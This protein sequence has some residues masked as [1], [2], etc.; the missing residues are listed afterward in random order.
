[1]HM[2]NM[3]VWIIVLLTSFFFVGVASAA[4]QQG[5]CPSQQIFDACS[6]QNGNGYMW[7]PISPKTYSCSVGADLS[8]YCSFGPVGE[9]VNSTTNNLGTTRY[10]SALACEQAVSNCYGAPVLQRP[11]APSY[12]SATAGNARADLSWGAATGAASYTLR[13]STSS[14]T[15]YV[16]VT[17][18]IDIAATSFVN[19]SLVNGTTYYYVV[20]AKNSGG[21]SPNSTEASVTP[22]VPPPVPAAPTNL[23]G[24]AGSG[25]ALLTWNTVQHATAYSIKRRTTPTGTAVTIGVGGVTAYTNTGLVDGTPYYFTVVAQNVSGTS[26]ESNTISVTPQTGLTCVDGVGSGAGIYKDTQKQL[27]CSTRQVGAE[28]VKVFGCTWNGI[29]CNRMITCTYARAPSNATDLLCAR[30]TGDE[31]GCGKFVSC[32]YASGACSKR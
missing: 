17:G 18:A 25:R 11:S 15:G 19:T 23:M 6:K 14:G 7:Y 8:G 5:V 12:L 4:F 10:P 31:S 20:T 24:V 26:P 27:F 29:Q 13:R 22:A 2:K 16:N 21:T 28:C 30:Y 1:M 32:T 9:K 3:R